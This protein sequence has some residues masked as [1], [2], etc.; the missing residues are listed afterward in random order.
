VN[1]K[2]PAEPLAQA[3]LATR[4]QAGL[5][6]PKDEAGAAQSIPATLDTGYYSEAA[7]AALET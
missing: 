1:D 3:T 5:E 6:C 7:V 4:T 2:Q